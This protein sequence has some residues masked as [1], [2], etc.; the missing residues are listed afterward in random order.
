MLKLLYINEIGVTFDY[1]GDEVTW[2][3][4]WGREYSWRKYY[5]KEWSA[6][7]SELKDIDEINGYG[8]FSIK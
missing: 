5:S 7:F 6:I 2:L 8:K 4:P 3:W 1:K